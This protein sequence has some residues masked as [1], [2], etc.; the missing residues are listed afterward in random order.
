MLETGDHREVQC[1][2]TSAHPRGA[3]IHRGSTPSEAGCFDRLAIARLGG[4]LVLS[5]GATQ[6]LPGS[7]RTGTQSPQKS[8]G[9]RFLVGPPVCEAI[10][11]TMRGCGGARS[12]NRR[13]SPDTGLDAVLGSA[14]VT[15]EARV[16]MPTVRSTRLARR[17]AF[18]GVGDR[19]WCRSFA[20]MRVGPVPVLDRGGLPTLSSHALGGNRV[21]QRAARGTRVLRRGSGRRQEVRPILLDSAVTRSSYLGQFEEQPCL[22][23]DLRDHSQ[24]LLSMHSSCLMRCNVRASAA[25]LGAVLGRWPRPHH[26][27]VAAAVGF[28]IDAAPALVRTLTLPTFAQHQGC[29]LRVSEQWL[30]GECPGRV[31]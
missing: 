14:L 30:C 21:R 6:A 15:D 9:G 17:R 4:S 31:R 18:A 26:R 13:R 24:I 5:A 27:K 12:C 29:A 22:R 16:R 1:V 7:G 19:L 25:R 20:P 28:V 11:E 10:A 2:L 8:F 23:C 3:A